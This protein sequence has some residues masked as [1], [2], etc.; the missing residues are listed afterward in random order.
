MCKTHYFCYFVHVVSFK[1][2]FRSILSETMSELL[3]QSRV[4]QSCC[5][6]EQ[7]YMNALENLPV[8]Q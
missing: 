4:L 6:R 8:W 1:N 2:M 5:V 3:R 7:E